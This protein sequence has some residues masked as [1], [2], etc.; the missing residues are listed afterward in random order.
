MMRSR[1]FI[2]LL[3]LPF[4]F[5]TWA[6]TTRF[7]L[8]MT[9][10]AAM[11]LPLANPSTLG[12]SETL[13]TLSP[14]P[15]GAGGLGVSYAYLWSSSPSN[16]LG[17]SLG[18]NV[19]FASPGL[20]ASEHYQDVTMVP[21]QIWEGDK[22][23]Q[24]YGELQ[25]DY[26]ICVNSAR[27]YTRQLQLAVPVML[28]GQTDVICWSAG[29]RVLVPLG[30]GYHQVVDADIDASFPELGGYP[31]PNEYVTGCLRS[32]L[33]SGDMSLPYLSV[34]LGGK[35]SYRYVF[36]SSVAVYAPRRSVN[37]GV[38]AFCSVWSM[39]YTPASAEHIVSVGPIAPPAPV[40]VKPL[41]DVFAVR[42][43]LPLEVGLSVSYDVTTYR[44]NKRLHHPRHIVFRP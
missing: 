24:D 32:K 28:T 23:P 39:P 43:L 19:S 40:Y 27:Q 29:A 8:E 42:H 35:F 33:Y 44:Y 36:D 7:S 41:T 25:V 13:G 9:G 14:S 22:F 17:V 16:G 2:F 34:Q 21:T 31:V 12:T 38:Y 3:L 20:S 10:G 15:G 26:D 11:Y 37:F 30:L 4:A 6:Q 1:L 18:L 5:A